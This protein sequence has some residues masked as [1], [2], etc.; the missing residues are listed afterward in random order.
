MRMRWRWRHRLA[1]K[2]VK[3][4]RVSTSRND[5][6]RQSVRGH[7]LAAADPTAPEKRLGAPVVV[8]VALVV[9]GVRAPLSGPDVLGWL[10]GEAGLVPV[11]LVATV[12]LSPGALAGPERWAV[13]LL[14][15]AARKG[16]AGIDESA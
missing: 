9:E 8:P 6:R 16:Q 1:R 11:L 12:E 2:P 15:P 7:T 5:L 3:E 4:T 13:L 10:V 14:L